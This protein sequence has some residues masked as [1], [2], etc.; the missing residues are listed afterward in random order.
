MVIAQSHVCAAGHTR[1][2]A[3]VDFD[4]LGTMIHR[5][6]DTTERHSVLKVRAH[7]SET[8]ALDAICVKLFKEKVSGKLAVDAWPGIREAI[9]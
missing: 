7:G 9:E 8:H 6:A 3:S 5:P 4:K 2:I 1:I